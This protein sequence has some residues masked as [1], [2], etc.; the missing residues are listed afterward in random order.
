MKREAFETVHVPR[1]RPVR[2]NHWLRGA[3][4]LSALWVIALSGMA[5]YESVTLDPW[6]FIG[7]TRGKIFFVWSDQILAATTFGGVALVFDAERF[8]TV[9]LLPVVILIAC[10]TVVPLLTRRV[11]GS[12]QRR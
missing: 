8:W 4:T 10:A 9:L 12:L 11:H 6:T 7:D 1:R 2:T 3:L 5:L